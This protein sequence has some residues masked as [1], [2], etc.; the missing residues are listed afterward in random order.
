M[1]VSGRKEQGRG[2]GRI[3]RYRSEWVDGWTRGCGNAAGPR[4]LGRSDRLSE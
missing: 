2:G 1:E 4:V 3:G